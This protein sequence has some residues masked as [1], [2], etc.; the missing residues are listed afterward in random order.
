[1]ITPVPQKKPKP[2]PAS[3]AAAPAAKTDGSGR[4]AVKKSPAKTRRIVAERGAGTTGASRWTDR[5]SGGE[6]WELLDPH[7]HAKAEV[8]RD[9]AL[10]LVR[11]VAAGMVE[12]PQPDRRNQDQRLREVRLRRHPRGD[13]RRL[14]GM[15][16]LP[17]GACRTVDRARGQARRAGG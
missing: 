6:Y 17:D 9:G 1:M 15:A 2:N 3:A 10:A 11:P 5:G 12:R 7:G 13:F 14:S 4:N 16:L 8:A